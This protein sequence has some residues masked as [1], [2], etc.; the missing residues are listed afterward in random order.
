MKKLLLVIF[1]LISSI[2]GQT[3]NIGSEAFN[4]TADR[5]FHAGN[6]KDFSDGTYLFKSSTDRS[7]VDTSGMF[8]TDTTVGAAVNS[9]LLQG[10]LIITSSAA[11]LNILDDFANGGYTVVIDSSGYLLNVPR[12]VY[13]WSNDLTFSSTDHNTVAWASGHLF[14]ANLDTFDID[15]GNTGDIGGIVYIYFDEDVSA[16]VLQT[17]T[18]AGN[19]VGLGRVIVAVA[20]PVASGKLANFNV[21]G[22]DGFSLVV[23]TTQI[24]DNAITTN[25][26]LANTILAGD[27]AANTITANELAANSVTTNEINFTAVN[28][29]SILYQI[30]A[31]AEGLNITGDRIQ[32]N[33]STTFATGYNSSDG[34]AVLYAISAPTTRI[35]GN[36]LEN[37]DSWVDTTSAQGNIIKVWTGTEWRVA[38]TYI[39]GGYITTGTVDADYIDVA[40]VI[41]AGS[42]VVGGDNLSD[43]TNDELYVTTFIQAGIPTSNGAGDIWID[44]DDNNKTYRAAIAGA[45]EIKAGE[46]VAIQDGDIA[47][48]QSTA[49]T[50][51]TN[52]Q[53]GITNAGTAQT[54]ADGKAQVVYADEPPTVGSYNNGDIWVD[55]NEGDYQWT[56]KA[57]AWVRSQTQISGAYI[58]T[59][60]VDA[61]YLDVTGIFAETV[62]ATGTITG[63]V[64]QTSSTDTRVVM[65]GASDNLTFYTATGQIVTVG[66]NISGVSDGVMVESST[67]M[68]RAYENVANGNDITITPY[69]I[70]VFDYA[71]GG[72]PIAQLTASVLDVPLVNTGQGDNN[73]YDMNQNVQT[74]DSPTFGHLILTETASAPDHVA[75]Y[76]KL[77]VS[78]ANPTRLYFTDD[79]GKDDL[80]PQVG[81]RTATGHGTAWEGKF[82]INIYDNKVY[83]Y[84]DGSWRELAAW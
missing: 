45:N 14:F 27:I 53:T 58:T 32:I 4:E 22:N 61:D 82:E 47:D 46:W 41:T 6:G 12:T 15:A 71:I 42:L 24:S 18:T 10:G 69:A 63:A 48:A 40:G 30:N 19:A 16:T 66:E 73:L 54:T 59:G 77:Y 5:L 28:Q 67:A 21:F 1:I 25:L 3:D 57:G 44:S 81:Y 80:I 64:I 26:I 39:D 74:S 84:A 34:S 55:T 79:T 52:A 17:I 76:G 72:S 62:T 9:Q 70:S 49:D 60:T 65:D 68:F 29:D 8:I 56:L 78:N 31:S 43:L 36:A 37:G 83:I 75:G 50:A 20:S 38:F 23:G 2:I 33:G 11:D 7:T 35:S 51:E 13:G